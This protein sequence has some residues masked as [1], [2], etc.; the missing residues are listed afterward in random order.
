MSN[1]ATLVDEST[2]SMA[3]M[4]KQVLGIG[5][6]VPVALDDLTAGLYSTRSAG[7]A[8]GDAMDVLERSARL[9]VAG[10]SSTDDAVNIVTSSLNAFKLEGAEAEGVYDVLF[11]A[12]K[13]GKTDLSQLGSGFGAVAG[14]MSDAG[15]EF[16][17]YIASVSALTT[18]GL[19]AAQAHTQMRAAVDGLTKSSKPLSKIFRKL[20]TKDFKSLIQESGGVVPALQKVRDAVGGSEAKMRALIGS[21]EGSAAAMSVTGTTY[22]AFT[23]TLADMRDGISEVDKGFEKQNRTAASGW[24]KTKSSLISA[25]VAMGKILIPALQLASEKIMAL[26]NWFEGLSDSTKKWIVRIAA[27]VA[28]LGPAL[29]VMGKLVAAISMITK[30]IKVM[31]LAMAANPVA[32]LAIVIGAA[33]LSIYSNWEDFEDFF[34]LLWDGV[35]AIFSGAWDFIEGIIARFMRGVDKIKTA[36]ADVKAY[37]SGDETSGDKAAT[38][39]KNKRIDDEF[40]AR[41]GS[42]LP[43]FG[44]LGPDIK[45]KSLS[46]RG[47]ARSAPEPA[48]QGSAQ[49]TVSFENVPQGAK[50]KAKSRDMDVSTN[51][52]YQMGEQ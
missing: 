44:G 2:E 45:G 18:T 24:K 26:S 11:T 9:G 6:R 48:K 32:A 31:S 10:L 43:G 16:D 41:T 15:I 8:A 17:E 30:A 51:T 29:I 19:P 47:A 46:G 5:R 34:A 35:K 27:V 42:H 23:E 21:S 14:K 12:V 28:V 13:H 40:F 22:Q 1:V 3:D 36:A 25:G 33:A 7:I 49:V 4:S 50:V 20:G 38:A 52:G 39:A 37:I